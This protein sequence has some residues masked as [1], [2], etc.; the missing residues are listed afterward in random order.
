MSRR[1]PRKICYHCGRYFLCG[2]S[3]ERTGGRL[4]NW[5]ASCTRLS[6]KRERLSKLWMDRWVLW[7]E[8]YRPTEG[9]TRP[10]N[11]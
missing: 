7:P 1:K 5:C 6:V 8:G 10:C 2:G 9:P 3:S 4:T 11:G